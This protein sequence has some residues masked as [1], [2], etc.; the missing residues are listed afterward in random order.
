MTLERAF[1]VITLKGE[2]NVFQNLDYIFHMSYFNNTVTWWDR[3]YYFHF[4][5]EG[6][7][8]ENSYVTCPRVKKKGHYKL[9]Y[10]ASLTLKEGAADEENQS[11][12]GRCRKDPEPTSDGGSGLR[13][14]R[15]VSK[16]KSGHP[17]FQSP[18]G[19]Q[20]GHT[21]QCCVWPV[22]MGLLPRHPPHPSSP[23]T[24]STPLSWTDLT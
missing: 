11:S 21:T 22:L 16:G 24:H 3:S 7:I 5:D 4:I 1:P 9:E 19:W 13:E 18:D 2:T 17:S 8:A 14:R 23:I 12:M 20:Q 10:K 15:A 6:T